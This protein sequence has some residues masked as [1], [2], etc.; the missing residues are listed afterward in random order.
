MS[1]DNFHHYLSNPEIDWICSLCSLPQLG[2]ED[3]IDAPGPCLSDLAPSM[4]HGDEISMSDSDTDSLSWY[5]ANV[6][7]Y[8][9]FNL[10]IAYLNINSI[11]NKIDE[12][13]EMLGKGMFDILFIAESKIDSTTS[14]ALLAQPGFRLARRDRKKGGGGLLVYIRA[15]L[16]VYRRAKLEP[17]DVE[18]ICLD[19]KDANT[20]RFLVC[21]CYRSPGKCNELEFMASMSSAAELMYKTRKELLLIGDFNQDMY[22]NFVE[23]RL[24]NKNLTDF[25]HRFCFVNKITEPTRVTNRTKSLL[26]VI[27]V[28]H[29]ERYITSGNMELGLRDHD[30]VFVVRKNKLPRPKPRLIEYRSMKNFDNVEFLTDLKYALGA[31]RIVSGMWTTSGVTG[32]LS[33]RTFLIGMHRSRKKWVRCDR[34]PW[35]SPEI[36]REIA[37]RNRLFKRYRKNPTNNLWV[38]YKQQRNKVT[39][40]KRKGIKDFCSNAT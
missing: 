13:K 10:K 6:S 8:Y 36:L 16:S 17:R 12:V 25:C 37:R 9:K 31:R 24:P 30:L 19:V 26:D 28:S 39:S 18:S 2:A 20:G 15:D 35:I 1:R 7:G 11:T 33:I 22:T 21:G 29:A 40:L 27:L 23:N 14:T 32:A 34:L 38:A 5:M 3:F 4:V